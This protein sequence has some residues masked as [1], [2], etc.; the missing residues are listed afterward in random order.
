MNCRHTE[1][2]L[3]AYLDGKL[4]IAERR[5]FEAHLAICGKCQE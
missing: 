2:Q 1:K 5:Q 3:I 4:T